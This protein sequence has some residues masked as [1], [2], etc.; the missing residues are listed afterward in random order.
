MPL[1][2]ETVNR[3]AL[4]P[5]LELGP[6]RAGLGQRLIIRGVEA[7]HALGIE[8]AVVDATLRRV[9]WPDEVLSRSAPRVSTETAPSIPPMPAA[10]K[11]TTVAS[12]A[13]WPFASTDT[14]CAARRRGIGDVGV[15]RLMDGDHLDRE[16]RAADPPT[17][18]VPMTSSGS[19]RASLA[20]TLSDPLAV[21]IGARIDRSGGRGRDRHHGHGAADRPAPRPSGPAGLGLSVSAE[22][23]STSVLPPD[24][25]VGRRRSWRSWCR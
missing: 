4:A 21:T 18:A 6:D 15:D 2:S 24:N 17:A 19:W 25:V 7:G 11:A 12:K 3:L 8:E 23:A 5:V 16:A 9:T 10:P 22:S 14:P 13:R 1:A 20:L